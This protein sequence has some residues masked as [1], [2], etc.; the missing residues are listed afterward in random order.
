MRLKATVTL[1]FIGALVGILALVNPF[2]QAPEVKPDPPWFYNVTSED[3]E[4][5]TIKTR[6]N[7]EDFIKQSA[8]SWH[9]SEPAGIPVDLNRWSGIPLLLSGPQSQRILYESVDDLEKFGLLDP[10]ANVTVYLN[11]G[12]MLNVI[13]GDETPDGAAHYAKMQGFPQLF[14]IDSSWGQVLI[15][16]VDVPPIPKWYL[17]VKDPSDFTGI[18]IIINDKKIEVRKKENKWQFEDGSDIEETR[19]QEI[20]PLISGP[21]YYKLVED[22]VMDPTSYGIGDDSASISIR[23]RSASERGVEFNDSV[24]FVLGNES[25]EGQYIYVDGYGVVLFLDPDWI[26]IMKQLGVDPPYDQAS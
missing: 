24:S 16:I 3:I 23:W 25:P 7:E 20:L 13:L 1:I 12:E 11:N 5:I 18:D 17:N 8:A 9:F 10:T 19:W 22:R 26:R 4:R 14:L 15:R 6:L 21:S 2:K